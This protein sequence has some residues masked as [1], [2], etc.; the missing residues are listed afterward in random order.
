[1]KA[2]LLELKIFPKDK[3]WHDGLVVG[4]W[5]YSNVFWSEKKALAWGKKKMREQLKKIKLAF[6]GDSLAEM[7]EDEITYDFTIYEIDPDDKRKNI[8]MWNR[9]QR[10]YDYK[11]KIFSGVD[12]DGY[13]RW[14]G[15]EDEAAGTKFELG[16]FVV[17]PDEK[18]EG[19]YPKNNKQQIYIIGGVPC[20]RKKLP[21]LWEN[22]YTL[23]YIDDVYQYSHTHEHEAKIRLYE[24]EIPADHPLHFLRKLITDEI[25]GSK[26]R[27]EDI[28]YRR[29]IFDYPPEIRSWHEVDFTAG[30]PFSDSEVLYADDKLEVV[31]VHKEIPWEVRAKLA[32]GREAVFNMKCKAVSTE[33]LSE[34]ESESIASWLIKNEKHLDKAAFAIAT[35]NEVERIKKGPRW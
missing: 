24:G 28:W 22:M 31:I 18:Y 1:M 5:H 17:L 6:K 19:R 30:T 10:R 26:E 23:D 12:K 8:E 2:Y 34:A 14:P 35:I 25:K 4:E 16:D 33:Q 7:V 21:N 9:A 32:D 27:W 11:G 15:D 13:E 3:R 29:I 20:D